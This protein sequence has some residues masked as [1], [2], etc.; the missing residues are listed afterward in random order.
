MN[1]RLRPICVSC[2]LSMRCAK[3]EFMVK[4]PETPQSPS[5]IWS[6]DRFECPSCEAS[7][8]TGFGVKLPP[9]TASHYIDDAMP[10]R[11]Q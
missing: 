2:Q 5:T 8:V 7:I 6:G 1:H 3:N 10:F 4:D 9:G 11:Y